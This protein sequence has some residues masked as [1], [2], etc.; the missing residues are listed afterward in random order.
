MT[1]LQD[2]LCTLFEVVNLASPIIASLALLAFFWGLAMFLFK[3]DG[4]E[5]DQKKGR[6]IMVWGV[7]ALFVMVSIW[8]IVNLLQRGFGTPSGNLTPPSLDYGVPPKTP[9][10]RG[11][12]S[13][14][15]EYLPETL[16]GPTPNPSIPLP[17]FPLPDVPPIDDPL[18]PTP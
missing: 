5:E 16:R 9:V 11:C 1:T 14:G 4:K 10:F 6:A 2:I 3:F 12:N 7:I 18:N 8:G 17:D 15:A 13:R